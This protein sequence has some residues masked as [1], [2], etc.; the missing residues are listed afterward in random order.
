MISA[1]P[2]LTGATRVYGIIADPIDHVKT[3]QGLNGLM[4]AR[5][6]DGVLVPMHVAPDRLAGF[7]G[8]V[9]GWRNFGGFIATVPH[10]SAVVE[11]CDEV[12]PRARAI[13]AAN[14]IRREADGRLVGDMLD[15]DGF[16]AG[17]RA[18]GVETRGLAVFL[19]G[20]GGA[21]NAIA[22]ALAEAG[23]ARLT[24][25]NRT[26]MRAQ[27][28]AARLAK[29]HPAL[30]VVLGTPDP[31]GHELV[32][33]ATSLGLRPGD[34]LPLDADRLETGMI[35]ADIIMQPETPPL[36]ARAEQKGCQ[37]QRGLPMLTG[38][39]DAMAR[40]LGMTS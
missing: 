25:H 31:A 35:V 28:L 2:P 7:L 6:I 8:G 3:P 9:R 23:I 34:A 24:I 32:V 18:A 40:F 38:Q 20:A 1:H 10:K 15:G 19:A 21:A 26:A 36:L 14:A 12:T 39:L 22:F 5:G 30:P 17:L 29:A 27:E 4:R 13:G 16:I 11:L 33:N 37:V